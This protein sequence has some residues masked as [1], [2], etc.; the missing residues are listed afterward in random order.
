MEASVWSFGG[1]TFPP[2]FVGLESGLEGYVAAQDPEQDK[3]N[4]LESPA[5]DPSSQ[6]YFG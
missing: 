6:M 3:K 1:A 4:Y 2:R 5:W